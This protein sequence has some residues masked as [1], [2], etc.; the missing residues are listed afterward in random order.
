MSLLST[1]GDS[2]SHLVSV[3]LD[4]FLNCRYAHQVSW[5][6][7]IWVDLGVHLQE[8]CNKWG[9]FVNPMRIWIILR[10]GELVLRPIQTLT[11]NQ[12]YLRSETI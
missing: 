3:L 4:W 8:Q 12:T 10:G 6:G 7:E 9:C 5:Q 11:Q 1:V 2:L